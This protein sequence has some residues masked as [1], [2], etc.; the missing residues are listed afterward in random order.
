MAR[1]ILSTVLLGGTLHQRYNAK[2]IINYHISILSIPHVISF[3]LFCTQGI[4]CEFV[5]ADI[6]NKSEC[7]RFK[8]ST[9]T[10]ILRKTE[11]P[12]K[13]STSKAARKTNLM[14]SRTTSRPLSL[15]LRR[16]FTA[17]SSSRKL[18]HIP[19]PVSILLVCIQNWCW[20]LPLAILSRR[21]SYTTISASTV[22]LMK[23]LRGWPSTHSSRIALQLI[24]VSGP[25]RSA[26]WPICASEA[27]KSTLILCSCRVFR[28]L[29]HSWR[30]VAWWGWRSSL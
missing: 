4:S 24:P 21:N 3:S 25:L 19:Q 1:L 11:R 13:R 23:I 9:L 8:T 16:N 2:S 17:R 15:T 28:I 27:E 29:V 10:Q 7:S 12:A 18:L 5:R 6:I 26:T 30:R 20:L 22:M 14:T